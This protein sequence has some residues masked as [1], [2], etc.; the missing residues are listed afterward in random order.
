MIKRHERWIALL[1]VCTF[2]WLLQV[3]TMPAAAAGTTGQVS[4][5]SVEQGPDY[6]EAMGETAAPAKKKS[7]LPVILIGVGVLAVTAVVL[8]LFVLNKYDIVGTWFI[9]YTMFKGTYAYEAVFSGSKKSGTL[10]LAGTLN[11]AY[12][13]D[14]KKV[15]FYVEISDQKYEFIGEFSSKKHMSGQFNFYWN[16]ILIP[17]WGGTFSADKK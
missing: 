6:Y 2:V 16:H 10:T 4:S 12:S 13:V 9:T 5:A 15:I 3:S 8:F 17:D 1:V 14:G 11:G 7:I